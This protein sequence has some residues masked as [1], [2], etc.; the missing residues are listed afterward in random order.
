MRTP[1]NCIIDMTKRTLINGSGS[2]MDSK[3]LKRIQFS[4]KLCLNFVN[5]LLDME[6]IKHGSFEKQ[7]LSFNL[8]TLLKDIFDLF[9]EQAQF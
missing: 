5:D 7:V 2:K 3:I 1:L 8:V 4:S 9:E 6:Q